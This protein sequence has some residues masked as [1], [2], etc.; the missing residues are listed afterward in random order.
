M[1]HAH[2]SLVAL[3]LIVVLF[4]VSSGYAQTQQDKS[5]P[6]Q[7]EIAA[8]REKAFKLLESVA[9]QLNT[10][11]SAENRARLAANILDSLWKHDEARARSL[12]R[13]VQDDLKTELQQQEGQLRY[14]QRFQVFFRLR[15]DTIDRILKYDGEAALE[16]LTATKPNFPE[17]AMHE[18][19]ESEKQLQLRLAKQV[20]ATNPDI[21][22]KL[23]REALERGFSRDLLLL[24]AKLN[25]KHRDKGQ[26]LYKEIV[27]K[28]R[29]TDV[30]E[31]WEQRY[32]AQ[33][34]VQ[35]FQ[36]PD[37]DAATYRELIGIFVNKALA[38]GCA[39]KLSDEDPRSSFC[40]WII[41][42]VPNAERYDSRAS[43][44]KH[45]MIESD[46]SSR[47][48]LV[49]EEAEELLQEGNLDQLEAL[50]GKYP[51]LRDM[52]STRLFH[53]VQSTGD[54]DQA[55]K[56]IDRFVTDPEKQRELLAYLES[57][58]KSTTVDAERSAEMD[59]RLEEIPEPRDKAW[60]L[61]GRAHEI[62]ATNRKDALKLINQASEVVETMKPGKE[63][64]IGRLVV[65]VS[66]CFEKSDRGFTVMETMVPKLNELVE[67]AAKLDGYDT[68]YLRD[69]EWNMSANGSV[70]EILT[71]LSQ[72][73]GYFA[74]CDFDR[75]VSLSSQF[76]RPEIRMMAHVKLAQGILAGPPPRNADR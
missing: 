26:V 10:L 59:R 20:A 16:F 62:G 27:E 65:A 2:R 22:L 54:F 47:L 58:K 18:L 70:G 68:N 13:L 29:Q 3:V 76:E 60:S 42:S 28:L 45:W 21:A 15:H 6:N 41:S 37:A 61:L 31:D 34:L 32:F 33:S 38:S 52:I 24:L 23:G 44:M 57:Q 74:W 14:D 39:N 48:T 69:G 63:Q 36:P 11:Q 19:R 40:Q 50:A 9:T 1:I 43:R 5:T 25:R 73:A 55:R 46:E 30:S 71:N 8:L 72:A 4:S 53:R 51:E 66:F 35:A 12:L 17:S 7:E 49:Y 67:V 75:A 64:T 56:V